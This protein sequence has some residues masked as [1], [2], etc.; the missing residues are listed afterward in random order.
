VW[1]IHSDAFS[2]PGS[3]LH[4]SARLLGGQPPQRKS[5]RR[6]GEPNQGRQLPDRR[7]RR[8]SVDVGCRR[9]F[10]PMGEKPS[11]SWCPRRR[12]LGARQ[13]VRRESPRLGN[14]TAGSRSG[15]YRAHI[16]GSPVVDVRESMVDFRG[17]GLPDSIRSGIGSPPHGPAARRPF[18]NPDPG[19]S[20]Y[21][22][23]GYSPCPPRPP[24]T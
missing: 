2:V 16:N 14:E 13:V 18:R 23:I 5:C 15:L 3:N 22:G 9:P 24:P 12:A 17:S 11:A 19:C 20:T 21:M 10:D 1:G 6:P 7:R 8:W 4:L